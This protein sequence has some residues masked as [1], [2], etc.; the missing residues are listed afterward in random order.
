[1]A[2]NWFDETVAPDAPRCILL[3]SVGEALRSTKEG[4]MPPSSSTVTYR[5][6]DRI[7]WVT[8]NRPEAL[9][10]LNYEIRQALGE[11]MIEA[12]Q[13][14]EVLVV[15]LSGEGGR[16]FCAGNDLKEMSEA[17]SRGVAARRGYF[18]GPE[19]W[20]CLKPVIAAIDGYALAGGMQL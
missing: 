11:A 12:S 7:A 14:D 16:A 2:R 17:D 13:D 6:Q 8:L 19:V 3:P 9:N 5:V 1:R 15:I 20:A 18:G 10:A 4:T